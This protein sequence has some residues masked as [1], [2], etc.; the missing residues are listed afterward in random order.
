MTDSRLN[1]LIKALEKADGGTLLINDKLIDLYNSGVRKKIK[2]PDYK[3]NK[4]KL[5]NDKFKKEFCKILLKTYCIAYEKY[6]KDC[7]CDE[8]ILARFW[9]GGLYGFQSSF[10]SSYWK[11]VDRYLRFFSNAS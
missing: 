9:A 8:E 11:E 7:R 2:N 10:T 5:N 1:K 3:L 6:Y 4:N